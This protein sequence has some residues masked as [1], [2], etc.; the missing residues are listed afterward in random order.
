MKYLISTII[1]MFIGYIAGCIYKKIEEY[2]D[3]TGRQYER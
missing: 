3:G 1:G 2:L